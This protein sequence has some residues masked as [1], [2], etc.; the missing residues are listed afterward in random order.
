MKGLAPFWRYFGGKWRACQGGTYPAP[1]CRTIVEPFAGGAGYALRWGLDRDVILVEKYKVIA[2]IWRWLI[3]ADPTMIRAIPEVDSIDDLPYWVPQP[4]KLLIGFRMNSAAASPRRTLSA[5]MRQ[6]RRAGR[7]YEGWTAATRERV[8]SQ[9][10]HIRHWKVIHGDY[11]LAP[12]IEATWFIDPPYQI[13]GRHYIHG[14]RDIDY[15]QLAAWCR[16]RQGQQ[17]VCEQAGASWLP[18]R[19]LGAFKAGPNSRSSAEAMW[20]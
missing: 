19:S 3:S 12:D 13:A 6:L 5:G 4:A 9:V 17:I 2:E 1:T 7:R 15:Q 8:A 10:V 18:F 11:T 16:A 14:C 20:P